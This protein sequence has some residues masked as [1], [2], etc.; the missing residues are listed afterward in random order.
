MITHEAI[1]EN[2]HLPLQYLDNY[3]FFFFSLTTVATFY[4]VNTERFNN[5]DQKE[6]S[7]HQKP[8][9]KCTIITSWRNISLRQY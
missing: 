9:I 6:T 2:K 8:N 3:D 1:P 7:E 5:L 4:A